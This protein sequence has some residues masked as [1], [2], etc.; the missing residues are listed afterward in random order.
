MANVKVIDIPLTEEH[1]RIA[2]NALRFFAIRGQDE[3][4]YPGN[5]KIQAEIDYF[6]AIIRFYEAARVLNK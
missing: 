4:N 2:L 3:Y 1:A 6:E 5:D